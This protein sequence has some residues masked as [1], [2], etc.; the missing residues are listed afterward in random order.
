[1]LSVILC[2]YNRA[3]TLELVLEDLSRQS[4]PYGLTWEL[5]VV[6]NN[7]KDETRAVVEAFVKRAPMPTRYLF[8]PRQ[9]KS[10]ALNTGIE[11]AEYEFLALTDDDVRIEADWVRAMAEAFGKYACDIVAGRIR[12]AWGRTPP[13][14]YVTAGPHSLMAVIVSFELGPEAMAVKQPPFGANMGLR[15]SMVIAAG[16]FRVDLGPRGDE[17][18]R[19][20]DTELGTR[21][22]ERGAVCHYVPEVVVDHPVEPHRTEK[23]YVLRWYYDHGRSRISREGVPAGARRVFGIP[24]YI[25][26]MIMENGLR[27]L[28]SLHPR[29][30]FYYKLETYLA[31][32]ASVQCRSPQHRS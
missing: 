14:W 3:R 5:I 25:I 28:T 10:F 4:V 27:W 9:G 21:L 15:R 23:S 16:G 13:D 32:G 18:T 12:A 24:I 22:I 6:D 17:L 8:E 20:E 11:R 26:R 29:R 1:M 7:S 31:L 19:A 2:T 30:R